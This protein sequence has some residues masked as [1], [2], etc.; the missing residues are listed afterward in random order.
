MKHTIRIA[1]RKSPLALIQ[2][3]LIKDKL[4]FL[5]R[6]VNVTIIG[7][8]TEGDRRLG[9]PLATVGGKG[10][11][12]KELE[13]A[14]LSNEADLAV[15]SM[16]DVPVTIPAGLSLEIICEREDPRD[17]FVANHY[18]K[19]MDLPQGAHIGTA[20]LRRQCQLMSLRP[21]LKITVLR[22]N[23]Q[24]R[25]AR[26]D[27]NDFDAIILAAAGLI[28]LQLQ[29]RIKE[30]FQPN[31][32][33]PAPG[34]GALGLECRQDDHQLIKLLQPLHHRPTEIC[35]AAERAVNFYLQGGCQVP[36]AA[37]AD[38]Y[39]ND[40]RVIGLVGNP[41][42]TEILKQEKRG[43]TKDAENMGKALALDLLAQGADKILQ[44]VYQQHG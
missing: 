18:Q 10:L 39:E 2:A 3:N 19:L 13:Q 17:V 21:D 16:K 1:S 27:A 32:F 34:Q 40:L 31:N 7:M 43:S 33:I 8:T 25:L 41:N 44:Q 12:V 15:H 36:I 22:G 4:E 35:V 6:D 23:V 29:E 24:T 30:Y 42:G 11:F 14:L 37:Y 9:M 20:S 28:R 38:M 5:Y 26:L